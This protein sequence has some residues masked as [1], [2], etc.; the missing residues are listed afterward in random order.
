MIKVDS[1]SFSFD[2]QTIFSNASFSLNSH[3]VY[4]LQ[5]ENGSGKTTL[6]KLLLGYFLPQDG[7]IQID[8]IN[9]NKNS[10]KQEI[11]LVR[12]NVSYLSQNSDFISFLNAQENISILNI[13]N[14][15][16]LDD[17]KLLNHDKF[18][19]RKG[20][21][22]SSGE[23]V[24]ISFERLIN[25]NKKIILLD[26]CSDFL[27]DKNTKTIIS[28]VKELG[29][30][31]LVIIVS[32]DPRIIKCFKQYIRIENNQI[33]SSFDDNI[34]SEICE[35][36]K[37]KSTR[38]KLFYPSLR[39]IKNNKIYILLLTLLMLIFNVFY[40]GGSNYITYPKNDFFESTITSGPYLL[41]KEKEAHSVKINDLEI[42]VSLKIQ[43]HNLTKEDHKI[44]VDQFNTQ[45]Y[46]SMYFNRIKIGKGDGFFHIPK[47][48]YEILI[49]RGYIKDGMYDYYSLFKIPCV[50]DKSISEAYIYQD[51]IY[52][53]IEYIDTLELSG[54]L[55]ENSLI[56]Y[57]SKEGLTKL[58]NEYG[59]ISF[60]SPSIFEQKYQVSL[61]KVIKD[62]ELY[63][64]SFLQEYYID[65]VL[66]FMDY[67]KADLKQYYKTF[68]NLSDVFVSAHL[69]K[70]ENIQKYLK[71]NE[72]LISE[73][74]FRKIINKIEYKES[75]II[76]VNEKNRKDF[77]GFCNKNNYSPYQKHI[78]TE[79]SESYSSFSYDYET[80]AMYYLIMIFLFL[81]C[82][83]SLIYIFISAYYE[84]Q[85]NN[86][87]VFS[88]YLKIKDTLKMFLTPIVL[89]ILFS[90]ILGMGIS[91][92][93]LSN[94]YTS[95]KYFIPNVPIN[96]FEVLITFGFNLLVLG[97]TSLILLINIKKNKNK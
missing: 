11:M 12:D 46:D 25:E 58:L 91:I 32:H 57:S 36:I 50:K 74:C 80:Y 71:R 73:E 27:D 43:P 31:K 77:I 65:Q 47:D 17:L 10:L 79:M 2:K 21:E 89:S 24:L 85:K 7:N 44:I 41:S 8:G 69:V 22:L 40:F 20:N 86:I 4:V 84:K 30:T 52:E 19:N 23:K 81:V 68:Y 90:F 5:G 6:L 87:L 62:N 3:G 59:K 64:S 39:L 72:V 55:W 60:V 63:Y 15:G 53:N 48:E 16:K 95:R 56:S 76:E 38:K 75:P 66:T 1:L 78:H 82:E 97:F 70:D 37:A 18:K 94:Y 35:N 54:A 33:I 9:L 28:K 34:S 26:E 61:S 83:C 51:D 88:R 29:K 49:D 14:Q 96:I 13:L 92:P 93:I 42:D 67:S 45:Y